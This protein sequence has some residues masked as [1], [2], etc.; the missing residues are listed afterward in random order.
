[1]GSAQY[2]WELSRALL[3][4]ED[5]I[6]AF[7]RVCLDESGTHEGSQ[8]VIVGAAWAKPSSWKAWTRDWNAAKRPIKVHH[9]VECHSR[10]GE[11]CGWSREQRDDY[12]KRI[13]PVIPKHK[14]QGRIAGLDVNAYRERLADRPDI[15]HLFGEPYVAC[16]NWVLS[17]ICDVAMR[18]GHGRLA[19]VHEIN[20]YQDEVLHLFGRIQRSYPSLKLTMAFAAKGDYVPL[21]CAD[22]FAYE[23]NHTLRNTD[24]PVRKP[25]QVIDPTGNSIGYVIWDRQNMHEFAEIAKIRFEQIRARNT[26]LME[27]A[28]KGRR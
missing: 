27:V 11:Y 26:K 10:K 14:I 2:V 21:Q 15:M 3:C 22:V 9:S 5:G 6:V 17:D 25:M 24:A 4:D 23:G 1:M 28:L 16:L 8:V 20:G 7:L 13:L 19:F 18:E 12:V